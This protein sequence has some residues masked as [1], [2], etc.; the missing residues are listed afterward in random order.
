MGWFENGG[1]GRS[2][3]VGRWFVRPVAQALAALAQVSGFPRAMCATRPR[4]DSDGALSVGARQYDLAARPKPRAIV[5]GAE[6]LVR[7]DGR[8]DVG[9]RELTREQSE[10]VVSGASESKLFTGW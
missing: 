9:F 4:S 1:A 3:G 10:L 8:A 2:G 6:E 5:T 7:Q